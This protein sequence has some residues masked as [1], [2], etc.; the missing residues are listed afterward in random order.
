V[1]WQ[2]NEATISGKYNDPII[3]SVQKSDA[4]CFINKIVAP[5][6]VGRYD[7]NPV[8]STEEM[9]RAGLTGSTK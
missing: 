9:E 8:K 4:D 5:W 7:G 3:V 2:E 1:E 6:E